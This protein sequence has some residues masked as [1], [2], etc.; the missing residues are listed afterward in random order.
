MERLDLCRFG[1]RFVFANTLIAA[2]GAVYLAASALAAEPVKV[3]VPIPPGGGMDILSR[4]LASEISRLQGPPMI[5]EN[6][7]G[8]FTMRGTAD[9]AHAA[10]DGNTLLI[11]GTSL[12]INPVLR[13]AAYDPLSFAPICQLASVP[14]VIA[15]SSKSRYSS[16][17]DL[18][19]VARASPGR[20]TMAGIGPGSTTQLAFEKLKHDAKVDMTFVPYP[21]TAPA[22]E[23]VLGQHVT[24]YFGE[25]TFVAAQAKAGTMRVLAVASS[26][27][28]MLLPNA[29]T[30]AELGFGNVTADIWFGVLAPAKTPQQTVDNFAALYKAAL[31]PP[32]VKTKLRT[33]G[34]YP[35]PVCGPAFGA[36]LKTQLEY[37]RNIVRETGFRLAQ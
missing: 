16:L 21:G 25:S 4:V 6:R 35:A 33:L 27:R 3:I 18:F 22:A 23:A 20:L 37:Y 5:V 31:A 9:V 26:H 32:V 19:N 1:S 28:S 7:P 34:L 24:A 30:L 10:P 8:A 12:V 14:V 2:I 15:V 11:S 13:K 29:P 36:F 17:S